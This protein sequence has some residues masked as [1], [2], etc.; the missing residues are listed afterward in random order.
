MARR[1]AVTEAPALKPLNPA[2]PDTRKL[3]LIELALSRGMPWAAVARALKVKDK[4][5]A[6]RVKRELEA[7]VRARQVS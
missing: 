1:A 3:A 6:K 2:D 5:A 4:A 7:R